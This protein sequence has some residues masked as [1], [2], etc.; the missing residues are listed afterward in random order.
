M[1]L[2]PTWLT[3]GTLDVEYKKY[4]LLA[5][6]QTVNKDFEEEK[7]YPHYWDLRRHYSQ[8]TELKQAKLRLSEKFRRVPSGVNTSSWSFTYE[9]LEDYSSAH[10]QEVSEILD[11]AE[12]GFA[13]TLRRGA[14]E[15]KTIEAELQVQSVGLLPLHKQEGY[16]LIHT[17]HSH[18]TFVYQYSLSLFDPDTDRL[19]HTK[20]IDQVSINLSFT[21][22]HLKRRLIS[23]RKE[24]PNPATFLV[25][26]SK[27]Y[28]IEET[29]LPLSK[30]LVIKYI[31]SV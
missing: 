23:E 25:R 15:I 2:T 8:V 5:Y 30:Q 27:D 31:Q 6:L 16:L 9:L 12:T 3:D 26:S 19:V 28:P 24:L 17:S 13:Q 18:P 29:L 1:K 11:F 10:L 21:F 22:E 20:L 7:Y 4:L 14:K